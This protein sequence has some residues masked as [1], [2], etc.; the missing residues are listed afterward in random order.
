MRHRLDVIEQAERAGDQHRHHA[1]AEIWSPRSEEHASEHD[2]DEHDE[3]TH[4]RCALLDKVLLR[5]VGT[6]L[7]SDAATLHEANKQGHEQAYD[8]RADEYGH[9]DLV[10]W[11]CRIT[12]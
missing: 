6:N 2:A 9:K 1:A 7:L 12:Q 3:P 10:S 5:P 11:V 4:S 8:Q